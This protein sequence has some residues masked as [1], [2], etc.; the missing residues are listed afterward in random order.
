[1][2]IRLPALV[3]VRK[4]IS[5]LLPP[6]TWR[7]NSYQRATIFFEIRYYKPFSFYNG[8]LWELKWENYYIVH[9]MS[10]YGLDMVDLVL[11]NLDHCW[12]PP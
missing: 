10:E 2:R 5:D 9:I 8:N 12:G 3:P 1:M 4:I 11:T 7:A 6:L